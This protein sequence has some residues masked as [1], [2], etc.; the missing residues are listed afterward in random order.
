MVRKE[1]KQ[2]EQEVCH[3]DDIEEAEDDPVEA[4]GSV[5]RQYQ[6]EETREDEEGGGQ[7]LQQA[8][9]GRCQEEKEV[10]I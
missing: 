3:R 1:G 6:L 7:D 8:D 10:G 2:E 4:R 5:E 9:G